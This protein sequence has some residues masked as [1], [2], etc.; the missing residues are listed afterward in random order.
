MEL[1]L[2]SPYVIV[3]CLSICTPSP[4]PFM[5]QFLSLALTVC[6][7]NCYTFRVYVIVPRH[8]PATRPDLR[9]FPGHQILKLFVFLALRFNLK[10]I[11]MKTE[12]LGREER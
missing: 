10:C 11:R 12:E 9:I 2:H 5:L 7:K 3:C 1:H 6:C 8:G 4:L